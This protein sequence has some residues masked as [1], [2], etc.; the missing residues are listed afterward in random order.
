[1]EGIGAVPRKLRE[2]LQSVAVLAG[3]GLTPLWCVVAFLLFPWIVPADSVGGAGVYETASRVALGLALVSFGSVVLA[4]GVFASQRSR[5]TVAAVLLAGH[6]VATCYLY[7]HP[8]LFDRLAVVCLTCQ[9]VSV[10]VILIGAAC[11]LP[12]PPG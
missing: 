10:A 3:L 1:M 12:E 2:A 5:W 4:S 11:G 8:D 9:G 6:T 7:P